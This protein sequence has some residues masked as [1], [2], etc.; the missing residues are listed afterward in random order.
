MTERY[1]QVTEY[2]NQLDGTLKQMRSNL[3]QA[4]DRALSENMTDPFTIFIK[5]AVNSLSQ[6]LLTEY[7][8]WTKGF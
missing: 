3:V 6:F 8:V 1:N 4:Y 5:E 2:Y 7:V